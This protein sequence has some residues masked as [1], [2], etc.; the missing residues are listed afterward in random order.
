MTTDSSRLSIP[1]S[2]EVSAAEVLQGIFEIN[3][4][5]SS[6][7]D[8]V[9]FSY[10]TKTLIR[11]GGNVETI[12]IPL[13]KLQEIKFKGGL[14]VSKIRL[15][16]KS[17]D[18][19]DGMPGAESAVMVFRVKRAAKRNARRFVADLKNRLYALGETGMESIPFQ[20]PD[21]NMGTTENSGLVYLD[22]EF[23]VFD[24]QSGLAGLTKNVSRTIKIEPAALVDVR[25][26]QGRI[27]DA[28]YIR[29]KKSELL[30]AMPGDHEVE[31]KLKIAKRHRRAAERLAGM[32]LHRIS[33]RSTAG[34]ADE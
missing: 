1:V 34:D 26:V 17:L 16:P 25:F 22:D 2:V 6:Q 10:R 20:L 32:I 4:I 33:S 14:I 8:A 29:P 3:G 13:E 24:L 15:L 18:V 31:V 12:R 9:E 27:K 11:Q 7:D 30:E 23:L 19:M 5:L 28:L 21:T